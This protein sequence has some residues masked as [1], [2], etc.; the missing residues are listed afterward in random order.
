MNASEVMRWRFGPV[1]R[2]TAARGASKARR[3]RPGLERLEGRAMMAVD[4][5]V[6]GAGGDWDTASNWSLGIPGPSTD[7]SL[8]QIAGNGY[9][10]THTTSTQDA[11]L[12]LSTDPAVTINVS[13]GQLQTNT[14]NIGILNVSAT[15][16]FF[17]NTGSLTAVNVSLA[18][19]GTFLVEGGSMPSTT[20]NFQAL[21]MSTGSTLMVQAIVSLGDAV[22]A[23]LTTP[24]FSNNG[25]IDVLSQTV[26]GRSF[27][28]ALN[29]PLGFTNSGTVLLDPEG[30]NSS[31][32]L[33]AGTTVVNNGKI[34]MNDISASSQANLSIKGA[35]SNTGGSILGAGTITTPLLYN[36]GMVAAG[37]TT[38]TGVLNVIGNYN[39]GPSGALD[40]NVGQGSSSTFTGRPNGQLNV[41]GA[42]TLGGNLNVSPINGYVLNNSALFQSLSFGSTTGTFANVSI[43]TPKGSIRPLRTV[44]TPAGLSF[45]NVSP[46]GDMEGTG[47]TNLSVYRNFFGQIL[48]LVRLANGTNQLFQFGDPAAGDI[49][50]P[51]DYQGIGK[52]DFAVFRR[53]TGQWLIKSGSDGS[54]LPVINFGAAQLATPANFDGTGKTQLAVFNP[55]TDV[56]TI[57]HDDGTSTTTQFGDVTQGD[58]PVPGDYEGIGKADLAVFR[59]SLNLWIIRLANGTI[60]T[61]QFGDNTQHDI[62]SPGAFGL[63]NTNSQASDGS[64]QIGVFRPSAAEWIVIDPG[65]KKASF[66]QFGDPATGDTPTR[67]P[68]V[69]Y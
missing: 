65:G 31:V 53:S 59:S 50:V 30:A 9:V 61:V 20:M 25:T 14:G 17:L 13:N 16:T 15:G 66:I 60:K 62:P 40:L 10:V 21:T 41:T 33:T 1:S 54:A 47:K 11:V 44:V 49:P 23:T 35:L 56:W 36:L 52:S 69:A 19:G 29:I 42:A 51:G 34:Q 58:T 37:G 22:N 32:T 8:P 26:L 48:W 4:T 45:S 12:D 18:S 24:S 39:Q 63:L 27:A 7:V 68:K 67:S 6:N 55:T 38:D 2:P 46:V 43:P 64:T 3:A 5:W 28:A 57:R